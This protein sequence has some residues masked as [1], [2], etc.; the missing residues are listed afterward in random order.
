MAQLETDRRLIALCDGLD[1]P[2]LAR[3]VSI[4]RDDGIDHRETVSA[5]LSHLFVH[6]VHHRGQAHAM[7][8]GT[9]VPP[10]QLDEFF[11]AQDAPARDEE[12]RRLEI[13]IPHDQA[14]QVAVVNSVITLT[15]APDLAGK[16]AAGAALYDYNVACTGVADR[17]PVAAV[18]TDPDS[19]AVLGGLWGRTELGLL[20]LDMFFLPEPLRGQDLGARLL[21]EVEAEAQRRG[22]RRAVVETS[23]FQAPGFYIRHGY[24]E[25][26]CVPFSV[27]GQ[28]RVFLSKDFAPATRPDGA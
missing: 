10:P 22:C 17:R 2:D 23:T 13:S 21:H 7:L 26:G 9:P 1:A 19:G 28:A 5:I 20:F 3:V 4:D 25:F 16:D 11:L 27:P 6:Q 15:D 14:G 8:A 12:L 24:V 18:A